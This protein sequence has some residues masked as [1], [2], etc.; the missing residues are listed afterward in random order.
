MCT[1]DT[2]RQSQNLEHYK[3]ILSAWVA[4]RLEKDR[5]ILTLSSAAIGLLVTLLAK[6]GV[7]SKSEFLLY[8]LGI[9]VFIVSAS[10]IVLIFHYN[11]VHLERVARDKEQSSP[12]LQI[13]DKSAAVLFVIGLIILFCI[14]LL[15]A[16]NSY[17]NSKREVSMHEKKVVLPS[18]YRTDSFDGIANLKPIAQSQQP[19]SGANAASANNVPNTPASTQTDKESK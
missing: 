15:S 5:A 8:V 2:F 3:A 10:L 17:S 11:S 14:D 9:L 16:A 13:L 4:T 18:Q 1:D 12:M 7:Q 6:F 19:V